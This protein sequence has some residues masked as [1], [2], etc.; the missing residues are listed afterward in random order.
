MFW[1]G[2]IVGIILTNIATLIFVVPLFRLDAID[3]RVD[4]LHKAGDR[5]GN[6]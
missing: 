6:N 4:I 3:K 1:I 5:D 2:L